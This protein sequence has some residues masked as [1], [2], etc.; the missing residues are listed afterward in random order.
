MDQ[1]HQLSDESFSGATLAHVEVQ[2]QHLRFL[3]H[4]ST[5]VSMRKLIHSILLSP[6]L[7]FEERIKTHMESG[8]NDPYNPLLI[9]YVGKKRQQIIRSIVSPPPLTLEERIQKDIESGDIDPHNTF[10][11]LYLGKKEQQI[12]RD[13][14][15]IL[16]Q[17]ISREL[18]SGKRSPDKNTELRLQFAKTSLSIA[19]QYNN[20][21][22]TN[23]N[24]TGKVNETLRN[25]TKHYREKY[26]SY[27]VRFRTEIGTSWS[28]I[29][30]SDVQKA[31]FEASKFDTHPKEIS[32]N[33]ETPSTYE[34]LMAHCRKE[35]M[36]EIASGRINRLV[37]LSLYAKAMNELSGNVWYREKFPIILGSMEEEVSLYLRRVLAKE[38]RE[39]LGTTSGVQAAAYQEW[40][41]ALSKRALGYFTIM[42]KIATQH[43]SNERHSSRLKLSLQQFYKDPSSPSVQRFHWQQLA[44]QLYVLM[45]YK[46]TLMKDTTDSCL[47]DVKTI[48]S[49]SESSWDLAPFTYAAD[50]AAL[51]QDAL[52]TFYS[53][54]WIAPFD[55]EHQKKVFL[56][57]LNALCSKTESYLREI[58]DVIYPWVPEHSS[59]DAHFPITEGTQ[60]K[61]R[62]MYH[63]LLCAHAFHSKAAPR[64]KTDAAF[65]IELTPKNI[66]IHPDIPRLFERVQL[67]RLVDPNNPG[68][69]NALLSHVP[70]AEIMESLKD[71]GG[72][73]YGVIS[74][75]GR[76]TCGALFEKNEQLFS[77][78]GQRAVE[79]AREIPALHD[80][81]K[82]FLK[83]LSALEDARFKFPDAEA[84]I[85]AFKMIHLAVTS[86]AI[87]RGDPLKDE[88]I[89]AW[90]REGEYPN[91]AIFAYKKTGWDISDI[92]EEFPEKHPITGLDIMVPYRLIYY[93][94]RGVDPIVKAFFEGLP[95][96]GNFR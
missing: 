94:A 15:E 76:F 89:L 40:E 17:Q 24:E 79:R 54:L 60:G 65:V 3:E 92:T 19:E 18:K 86:S 22:S 46:K 83:I 96:E 77:Y 51:H 37:E 12:F 73:L 32:S 49:N 50:I 39:A 35:I 16:E 68:F 85:S 10:L 58:A 78:E 74:D 67:R 47:D 59:I 84:F 14:I 13:T 43:R 69:Q 33:N 81:D 5:F 21:V 25:L 9:L 72:T 80:S 90:V 41:K 6:P 11:I 34:N 70:Y 75:K 4:I 57:E 61:S 66:P 7:T 38:Q 52:H 62:R 71:H 1:Y 48:L 42:R 64:K 29:S 36:S 44:G 56:D 20:E 55:K 53:Y 93:M 27:Y 95:N 8:D 88:C 91:Q 30:K 28:F 23:V 2:Q 87:A 31:L 63:D 26:Y 45:A 82:S